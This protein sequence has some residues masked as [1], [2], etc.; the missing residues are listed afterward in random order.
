MINPVTA[1]HEIMQSGQGAG[2]APVHNSAAMVGGASSTLVQADV[3]VLSQQALDGLLK[4]GLTQASS[5]GAIDAGV[6]GAGAGTGTG[7]GTGAGAGAGVEPPV[8][9]SLVNQIEAAAQSVAAN[10]DFFSYLVNALGGSQYVAALMGLQQGGAPVEP[11]PSPVPPVGGV[12]S[13]NDL[14][15]L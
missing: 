6:S 13:R 8:P 14:S 4:D 5:A 2:G 15:K 9:S 12:P 11:V 3:V 7:V 10:P 1:I